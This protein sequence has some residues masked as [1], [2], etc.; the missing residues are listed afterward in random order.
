MVGSVVSRCSHPPPWRKVDGS[1]GLSRVRVWLVDV[2]APA[3]A[4]SPPVPLRDLLPLGL[5][6]GVGRHDRAAIGMRERASRST[7]AFPTKHVAHSFR[8]VGVGADIEAR[9]FSR[10]RR[11]CRRRAAPTSPPL[12]RPLRPGSLVGARLR[13]VGRLPHPEPCVALPVRLGEAPDLGAP[14]LLVGSQQ[15]CLGNRC[16][17]RSAADRSKPEAATVRRSSRIAATSFVREFS[18][19]HAGRGSR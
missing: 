19:V 3:L 2:F 7:R 6:A 18:A 8:F 16:S 5:E 4:D 13:G 12:R 1:S 10:R 11:A 14:D 15:P 17:S 9:S